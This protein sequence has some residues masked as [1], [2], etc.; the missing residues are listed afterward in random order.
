MTQT[1][2]NEALYELFNRIY[3]KEGFDGVIQE[4][5]DRLDYGEIHQQDDELYYI[6]TGGWSDD[7]HLL[8]QL[9][10]ILSKFGHKHYVGQLRG[11]IYYFA[12][13][14]RFESNFDIVNTSNTLKTMYG[15]YDTVRKCILS[16]HYTFIDAEDY[17]KELGRGDKVIIN[18]YDVLINFTRLQKR[19]VR[20]KYK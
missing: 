12:K 7:E 14:D 10:Y 1:K 11:G 4:V 3:D 15:L 2:K 17:L 8:N 6:T 18:E 5:E 9:T 19:N 20:S 16:F 13:N